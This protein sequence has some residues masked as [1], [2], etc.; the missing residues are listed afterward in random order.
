MELK[1]LRREA[2]IALDELNVNDCIDCEYHEDCCKFCKTSGLSFCDTLMKITGMIDIM[3]KP[4][5]N[6][7]NK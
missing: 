5:K 1:H 4:E 2:M 6:N 7:L 3:T